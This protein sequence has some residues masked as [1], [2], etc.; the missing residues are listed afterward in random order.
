MYVG[1]QDHINKRASGDLDPQTSLN[2]GAFS[3]QGLHSGPSAGRQWGTAGIVRARYLTNGGMATGH[4]EKP[5]TSKPVDSPTVA[6]GYRVHHGQGVWSL[7]YELSAL[8]IT[9]RR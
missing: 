3:R 2:R 9:F 8:E 7:H 1:F 5:E 6:T 4:R